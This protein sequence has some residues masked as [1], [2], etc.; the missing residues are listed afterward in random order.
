MLEQ[1]IKVQMRS[2]GIAVFFNISARM[3]WVVSATPRPV[4]PVKD[5]QYHFYRRLGVPQGRS[6]PLQKISPPPGFDPQVWINVGIQYKRSGRPLRP[7][8]YSGVW[9]NSKPAV[10][11][12]CGRQRFLCARMK[13]DFLHTELGG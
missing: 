6:G 7:N 1:A 8:M 9:Q 12:V 10:G 5:N 11:I 3:R 13:C 4:Y 2:R